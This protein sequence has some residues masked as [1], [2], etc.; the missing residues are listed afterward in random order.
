MLGLNELCEAIDMRVGDVKEGIRD[1]AAGVHKHAAPSP[2]WP[3][4]YLTYALLALIC[5]PSVK[6]DHLLRLLGNDE[7]VSH[8][9]V[10]RGLLLDTRGVY[11]NCKHA[12]VDAGTPQLVF[13]LAQAQA[14]SICWMLHDRDFWVQCEAVRVAL[15]VDFN[16]K[17]EVFAS[18]SS[19]GKMASASQGGNLG[20]EHACVL[21]GQSVVL[22]DWLAHKTSSVGFGGIQVDCMALPLHPCAV[23]KTQLPI[24]LFHAVQPPV[25]IE[26]FAHSHAGATDWGQ[27]ARDAAGASPETTKLQAAGGLSVV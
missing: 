9:T 26:L 13:G 2:P 19:F 4:G 23:C 6:S 22:Q 20:G 8:L 21:V 16:S 11:D 10:I 24:S 25:S 1:R 5:W 7:C 15:G 3:G 14:S 17:G 12:F 27:A 18:L